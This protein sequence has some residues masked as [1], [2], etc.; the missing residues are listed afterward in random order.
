MSKKRYLGI[1]LTKEV[2]ETVQIIIKDKYPTLA[3]DRVLKYNKGSVL[4]YVHLEEQTLTDKEK[5]DL[6][7]EQKTV[8]TIHDLSDHI[9]QVATLGTIGK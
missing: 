5:S 3:Y 6:S 2:K 4:A 7:D 8:P 9:R 1:N